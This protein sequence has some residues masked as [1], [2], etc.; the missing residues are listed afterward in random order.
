[1][2]EE[3][4]KG[5]REEER[6]GEEEEREGERGGGEGDSLLLLMTGFVVQ[7]W[8]SSLVCLRYKEWKR[9]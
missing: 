9:N 7:C 2:R 5:V 8:C 4:R 1:M 6:K 3:E